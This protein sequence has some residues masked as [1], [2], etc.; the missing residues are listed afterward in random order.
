PW[1]ILKIWQ[2]GLAIHGA[3]AG[4]FLAV[5]VWAHRN[6]ESVWQYLDLLALSLPLGQAI[7]RWG[8][9]FNQELFGQPTTSWWGIYIE[10]INRPDGWVNFSTFQPVFLYES[11]LSLAL[12]WWLWHK[13][14][15]GQGAVVGWYLI[16][17]GIIRFVLEFIRLDQVEGLLG[18]RWPQI[19]SLVM[20]IVGLIILLPKIKKSATISQFS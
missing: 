19:I 10:A 1:A 17:Y 4:G 2:G 16:G 13:R 7:G 12:F 18:L 3:L 8:N 20:V 9:Y 6:K 14:A 11:L 15:S 5:V